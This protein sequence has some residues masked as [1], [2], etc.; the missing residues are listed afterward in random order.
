MQPNVADLNT[1]LMSEGIESTVAAPV[2]TEQEESFE[3]VAVELPQSFVIQE[4]DVIPK[5]F[6]ELDATD[7]VVTA[8]ET[9][10]PVTIEEAASIAEA[11]V[12]ETMG[13]PQ[14][15]AIDDLQIK[16]EDVKIKMEASKEPGF[17]SP[18]IIPTIKKEMVGYGKPSTIIEVPDT[19]ESTDVLPA[20]GMEETTEINTNQIYEEW[21][22]IIEQP[23]TNADADTITEPN[24]ITEVV[25]AQI[26]PKFVMPEIKK[27]KRRRTS[28]IVP[29]INYINN[30]NETTSS[31]FTIE[32]FKIKTEEDD[33]WDEFD[34]PK[35]KLTIKKEKRNKT[36]SNQ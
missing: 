28:Q 10:A 31:A 25:V 5:P 13:T 2:N 6:E 23:D 26:E 30:N 4:I 35:P 29:T 17:P 21:Y 15:Q 27:E 36:S 33:E 16:V 14:L 34:F 19:I 3:Q 32:E 20:I 12:M 11:T 1:Q 18:F 7:I 24:T 8:T 22:T 9:S